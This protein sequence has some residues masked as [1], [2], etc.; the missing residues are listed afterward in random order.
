[1]NSLRYDLFPHLRKNTEAWPAASPLVSLRSIPYAQH[2]RE[3]MTHEI[4]KP[5]IAGFFI[6][7]FRKQHNQNAPVSY[8]HLMVFSS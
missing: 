1:M 2:V 6:S 7:S 8:C 4:K 3:E 5:A